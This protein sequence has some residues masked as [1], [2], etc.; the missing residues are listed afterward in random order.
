[1]FIWLDG[2][3]RWIGTGG[4]VKTALSMTVGT[5]RITVQAEDSLKRYFQST[6]YATVH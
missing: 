2:V 6:V 4:S 5:H 3:K 1:M